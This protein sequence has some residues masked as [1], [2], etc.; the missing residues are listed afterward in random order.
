MVDCFSAGCVI[1]RLLA[2]RDLF[3]GQ[4]DIFRYKYTGLPSPKSELAV[5]GC[6]DACIFL[7]EGLVRVDPST[8]FSAAVAMKHPW[9]SIA[10]PHQMSKELRSVISQNVHTRY[11]KLSAFH[12]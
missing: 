9:I 5:M 6:G 1:Y 8:R 12:T 3:K 7:V 10:P 2:G 11:G 4:G